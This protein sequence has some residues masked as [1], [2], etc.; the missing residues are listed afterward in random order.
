MCIYYASSFSADPHIALC[1]FTNV[2]CLQNNEGWIW[3]YVF[4]KLSTSECAVTMEHQ[5]IPHHSLGWVEQQGKY[6][7]TSLSYS[8]SSVEQTH[9]WQFM[10]KWTFKRLQSWHLWMKEMQHTAYTQPHA[11]LQAGELPSR[12]GPGGDGW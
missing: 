9:L 1:S 12:K 6:H 3:V 4:P 11:A 2:L 10:P 8:C 7:L 5:Q